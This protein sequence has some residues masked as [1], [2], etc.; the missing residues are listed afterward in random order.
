[1]G[2]GGEGECELGVEV[3]LD[4]VADDGCLLLIGFEVGGAKEFDE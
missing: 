2:R 3:G 4:W 1:M